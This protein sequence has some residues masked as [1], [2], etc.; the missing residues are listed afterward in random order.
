MPLSDKV[1]LDMKPSGFKSKLYLDSPGDPQ[2]M[3]GT[4]QAERP[5]FLLAEGGNPTFGS[6]SGFGWIVERGESET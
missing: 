5:P 6:S 2:T 3:G 4:D 1:N